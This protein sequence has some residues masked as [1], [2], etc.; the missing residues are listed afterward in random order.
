VKITLEGKIVFDV[1]DETT[2]HKNQSSWKKIAMVFI[3]GDL[4]PYY[5]WFIERRFNLVLNKP[6]RGAHVTFINDSV[7]EISNNG[8]L[9]KDEVNK[10]WEEV[11][12]KWNG[13]KININ[14]SLDPRTDNKHW[15]LKIPQEDRGELHA[16][17]A[18]LGLGKP[19][20]GLHMTIGYAN[21]I[22]EKHSKYIHDLIT[23]DNKLEFN[24]V[25]AERAK[26]LLELELLRKSNIKKK[27]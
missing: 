5:A 3:Q 25:S 22:N 14:L 17:R 11:K 16:I 12:K 20:W 1:S 7:K 26:Y 8:K 9:T 2:K 27:R 10:L 6:L 15:W 23:K 13:K 19:F 18:E 24:R 21:D 4:C